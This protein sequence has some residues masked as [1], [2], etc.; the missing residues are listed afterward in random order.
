[1]LDWRVLA[2]A[3]VPLAVF[4]YEGRGY[5]NGTL[6]TGAGAPLTVSLAAE[7]FVVLM[8]LTAFSVL[9]RFGE[10]WFLPVLLVQSLLL[11]AAGE[12]EP[13]LVDAAT[14]IILMARTGLR[15]S[16]RQVR[17]TLTVSVV[18]I[19]AITGLRSEQG[20]SL[21]YKD[22]GLGA[23]VAALGSGITSLNGN[24]VVGEAAV[25]LDGVDFAGGI[26]QAE[27]IGYPRLSAWAVPESL[28]LAVPSAVYPSKLTRGGLNRR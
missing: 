18:A 28:L 9:L 21:F 7:F 8:V 25:R 26:I 6:A 4:T 12:R 24:G 3:L 11:A 1:M 5:N 19:L 13:I 10:L 15:P 27:A 23:R 16:G 22:S 20:R 17:I 14:L 2:C